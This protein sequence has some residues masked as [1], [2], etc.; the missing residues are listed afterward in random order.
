[1]PFIGRHKPAPK[2]RHDCLTKTGTCKTPWWS[3]VIP[4]YTL[5][6]CP[7][8]GLIFRLEPFETKDGLW[9]KSWEIF[10]RS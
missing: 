4:E 3:F 7:K 5:W 9:G 10:S 8:C 6:Q 2:I 1:M